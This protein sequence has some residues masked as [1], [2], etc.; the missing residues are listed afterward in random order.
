MRE[1][2]RREPVPGVFR[3]VLPLP[4]EGLGSVNAFLLHDDHEPTLVDCGIY[5][6]SDE[7]DHG[8]ADIV[9]ALKA[10][11]YSPDRIRRLVIT[12]P[13]IDHYGLASRFVQETGCELWMHEKSDEDLEVYREPSR[14]ASGLR[15]MFVDHGVS[16]EEVDEIMMFEDW[17]AFISGLIEPT[18]EVADG[19]QMN[20]G[21]R[22]WEF[23]HTPGHSIS[24]ICLWNAGDRVLISGDHLLGSITPHIDFRRGEDED[25]LGGFLDSLTKIEKLAPALVLPGHRSPFEDGA[26][27]ARAIARHHD[28]RLGSILQVVRRE[29]R[30]AEEI[31]DEIFPTAS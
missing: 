4:F 11:D 26:E 23:V 20:V 14:V 19:D 21:G 24:H 3:L 7:G 29:A 25:P 17:R 31:T 5:R 28:R 27:R 16:E 15:E 10:C 13:H 1:H 6:P 8:W 22:T 2:R 9:G 18:S 12:H 30:T